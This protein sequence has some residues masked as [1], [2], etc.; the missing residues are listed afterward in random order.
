MSLP[1]V[2]P[3]ADLLLPLPQPG[4]RWASHLVHTHYFGFSI[5]EA[6]LGAFI[7]I[8]YQPAFPLCQGGVC[9]FSGLDN[10]NLMDIDFL[11]YQNTMPWPQAEPDGPIET[12]NGLRITYP[13]LGRHAQVSYQSRDGAT[14]FKI[15]QR[16]ISPLLARG[17]VVPGEDTDADPSQEPGGFEQYMRCTGSLTLHGETHP[18][19]CFAPRDRSWRQI[20][21]ERQ[22]GSVAMPG[23]GWSPICFGEDLSWSQVSIE[24]PSGHP[25]WLGHFDVPAGR[26]AHTFAWICVDGETRAITD[27]RRK[28]HQ[29]HPRLYS[30]TR[31]TVEA[32]DE[33]GVTHRFE[34]TAIAAAALPAWPNATFRDHVYRWEAE[35]GRVSH[36]TYQELWFDPYHSVIRRHLT[37]A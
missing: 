7:Y 24:A 19:D 26:P 2:S 29:H 28:V 1:I 23:V 20:R 14:N 34:G 6:A 37:A 22:G 33:S 9:I 17:H 36:G 30:A 13:E 25:L 4:E 16:A 31:Q 8:R 3:Q 11:D 5:P 21:A 27:V 35:D 15:D 10:V 12:A 18:I 32:D